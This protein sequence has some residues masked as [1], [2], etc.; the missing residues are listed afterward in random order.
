MAPKMV[1]AKPTPLDICIDR[2]Y[3]EGSDYPTGVA[4]AQDRGWTSIDSRS[5]VV[6][7]ILYVIVRMWRAQGDA[8]I[9]G[10]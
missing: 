4:A 8:E 9:C 6:L 3:G 5:Y 1:T 10:E 2:G 7:D